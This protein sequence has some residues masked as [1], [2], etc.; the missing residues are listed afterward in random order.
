MKDAQRLELLKEVGGTK[1][2]EERRAESKKILDDTTRK[3]R[4]I[5]SVVCVQ[6]KRV[7]YVVFSIHLVCVVSPSMHV[8]VHDPVSRNCCGLDLNTHHTLCATPLVVG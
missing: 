5:E 8:P 1:T 3:L 7:V 2:Y 6:G 4:E